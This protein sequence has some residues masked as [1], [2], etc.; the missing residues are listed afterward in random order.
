[1]NKA[2]KYI[3][4]ITA[5]TILVMLNATTAKSQIDAQ[6]SQYWAIPGYYNPAAIG[7]TDFID[8]HAIGTSRYPQ[9]RSRT[10]QCLISFRS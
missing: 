2:I 8:I 3:L 7:R 4:R 10:I 9:Y 1:M 6:Y 5:L